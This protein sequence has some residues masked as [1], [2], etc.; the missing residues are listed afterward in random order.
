MCD[1]DDKLLKPVEWIGIIVTGIA[2]VAVFGWAG[3]F[4]N[5][6]QRELERELEALTATGGCTAIGVAVDEGARTRAED[7]LRTIYTCPGGKMV[8]K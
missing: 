4:G 8:I 5:E 3:S 1:K 7:N 2:V 6:K